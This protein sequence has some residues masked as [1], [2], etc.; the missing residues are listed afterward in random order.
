MKTSDFD[1]VLPPD[2]IAERPAEPR[3]AARL[4]AVGRERLDDRRV[5]DLP[6]LLASGDLLIVNDTR[7]I[8]ARL[9]GRR[10]QARVEVTLHRSAGGGR[11]R[12]LARP[13]KR[14]HPGDV[15]HFAEGFLALVVAREEDGDVLLDFDRDD[16]ALM[17]ALERHGRLPLPPY[18]VRPEGAD[19]RDATDYQTV[20]ARTAGAIAA[21]TA[22]LHFTPELLVRLGQRGIAITRATLHVGLG[23]FLPVKVEDPREHRMHAE[24]GALTAESADMINAARGQGRRVIAVGT[25]ALRL[26]EAAAAPDGEVQPFSGETNLFILP[27][28]RFR[29]AHR[30][31]TN[32]HLPRSTLFM[33]VSAFAGVGRMREAY[34]HA[35]AGGYRFYSYGDCCLLDRM[36]DP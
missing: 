1:F 4:L 16:A 23:T 6:E 21:P 2:R 24:I 17:A 27:G 7:V 32:F 25:T 30:L 8:P 15:I 9:Y 33:L 3:E 10:G 12:A 28:Y 35:I 29:T 13:A 31:L 34:A 20:F 19:P 18:I 14:L 5:E 22:G 36:G 11:W 26:L